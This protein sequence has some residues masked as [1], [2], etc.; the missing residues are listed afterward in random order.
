VHWFAQRLQ[1]SVWQNLR[2]D[3]FVHI[4]VIV[5]AAKPSGV[6]CLNSNAPTTLDRHGRAKLHCMRNARLPLQGP[7][8]Q[9]ASLPSG[10]TARLRPIQSQS[11]FLLH[12]MRFKSE[13]IRIG[14]ERSKAASS[15]SR[16]GDPEMRPAPGRGSIAE[17][18]LQHEGSNTL[19]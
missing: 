5:P 13:A 8:R 2:F 16:N 1:S 19:T 7:T 12:P 3:H 6:S 15:S 14:R 18:S 10:N 11:R 4:T 17:S 9:Y